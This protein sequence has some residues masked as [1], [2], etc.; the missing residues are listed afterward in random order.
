MPK[1]SRVKS[2]A[3]MRFAEKLVCSAISSIVQEAFLQ[4]IAHIKIS[5]K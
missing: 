5:D 4:L 2:S 1:H 3:C